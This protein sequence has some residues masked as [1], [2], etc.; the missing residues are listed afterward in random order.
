MAVLWWTEGFLVY[1]RRHLIY[2]LSTIEGLLRCNV[3]LPEGLREASLDAPNRRIRSV[4]LA[5]AD[6]MHMGAT[7]SEAIKPRSLFFPP[8]VFE[9]VRAA[10]L[11]G[12][13]PETIAALIQEQEETETQSQ[14]WRDWGAYY[15]MYALSALP[16][17]F[18]TLTYVVPEFRVIFEDFGLTWPPVLPWLPFHPLH[19]GIVVVAILGLATAAYFWVSIYSAG[20]SHPRHFASGR[21]GGVL[22]YMPYLRSMYYKQNLGTAAMLAAKALQGGA[23]LDEVLKGAS[24]APIHSWFS[25]YFYILGKHVET[26]LTLDEAFE[27]AGGQLPRSFTNLIILGE[28][29]GMLAEA[30]ERIGIVYQSDV[31]RMTFTLAETLAPL[32]VLVFGT[33]VLSL[34]FAVYGSLAMLAD[35]MSQAV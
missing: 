31:R 24:N 16:A 21:L 32:G 19:V 25:N 10:E 2:V 1:R 33:L 14:Y 13:I 28:R 5:L 20:I 34:S 4:L 22:A 6:D 35:T 11:S 27:T 7:L 29:S 18:F 15:A 9:H 12:A 23:N 30:F 26:G 3:P 17:A 8:G